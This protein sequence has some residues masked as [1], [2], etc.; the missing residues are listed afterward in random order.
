ME[1]KMDIKA[2][3]A[4]T[5]IFICLGAGIGGWFYG[6]Y[7]ALAGGLLAVATLAV[8]ALWALSNADVG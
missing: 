5:L 6:S 1:L 7:G 3:L 4:A 2:I 8:L